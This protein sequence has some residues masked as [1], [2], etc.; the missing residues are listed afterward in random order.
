M[1]S[2]KEIYVS[3]GNIADSKYTLIIMSDGTVR[4]TWYQG[5]VR[6]IEKE[7]I[8]VKRG[9]GNCAFIEYG[10]PNLF[11]IRASLPFMDEE[12]DLVERWEKIK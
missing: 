7:P 10:V 6:S 9:I 5:A 3:D 12:G 2:V 1:D 8:I 4:L 11:G